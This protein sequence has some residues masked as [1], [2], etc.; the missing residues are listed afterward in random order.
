MIQDH[1]RSIW[2]G[3][4]DTSYVMG[5]WKTDT[6]A[7]W[8]LQKLG[9]NKDHFESKAMKV[10]TFFEHKI[11][12]V[13]PRVLEKDKQIVMPELGL[14]VNYDGT[15]INYI[16][17]CKTSKNDYKL[18]KA[19]WQ[20]AQVEMFAMYYTAKVKPDM[21]LVAYKVG[22][23]EYINYF[24]PIDTSRLVIYP[25]EYDEKFIDTYLERLKTLKECIDRGAKP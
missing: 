10:G 23:Q 4:S 13:M 11:L 3:A 16:C 12:D 8:W 9:V 19:H 5:N 2:I 20:Q 15:G 18:T 22:E 14:R 7:R 1:D 25:I 21:E 17:E 6:F 24:T